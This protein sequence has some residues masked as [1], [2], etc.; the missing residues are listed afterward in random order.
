MLVKGSRHKTDQ[1]S[2]MPSSFHKNP[3]G[4]RKVK[5]HALF[6]LQESK[7]QTIGESFVFVLHVALKHRISSKICI[8]PC[9]VW[10]KSALFNSLCVFGTWITPENLV[11][12]NYAH[13]N[14][15]FITE[16]IKQKSG[17]PP[18]L[19]PPAPE[20]LP[21]PESTPHPIPLCQSKS[22]LKKYVLREQ[23]VHGTSKQ[24]DCQGSSKHFLP[25]THCLKR[26]NMQVLS[27]I[28]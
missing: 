6:L 21:F 26:T 14:H 18:T 19:F 16:N 23:A 24:S 13:P 15:L 20:S 7:W 11:S 10:W 8:L 17:R 25:K 28:S 22:N 4:K 9:F 3:T 1:V 5:S 12:G 2:L 27:N